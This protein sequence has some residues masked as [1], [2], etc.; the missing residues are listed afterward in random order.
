[1]TEDTKEECKNAE[2]EVESGYRGWKYDGYPALAAW[3]ASSNDFFLLRRFS[4]TSARVLLYLQNEIAEKERQLDAMDEFTKALPGDQGGCG[5]F[6]LDAGSPREQLIQ[7]LVPL[8]KEYCMQ[9]GALISM[10]DANQDPDE[11]FEAFSAVKSR[12]T[13]QKHQVLN[14]Q[15]WFSNHPGAIDETEQEFA[16][17]T[18]DLVPIISKPK[19]VFRLMAERLPG[20][21]RVF[22]VRP[23]EDHV[24]SD[25]TFYHSE[26]ALDCF[27]NWLIIAIGLLM[28]FGPLWWL[29]F[30][31]DATTQLAINTGFITLFAV[32]IASATVAKPFEVLASTAA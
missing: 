28:L 10:A 19:P 31:Q 29:N 24:H 4:R 12:P 25:T 11:L 15:T 30:V 1:M 20:L 26:K 6:R 23:R 18:G 9:T 13:A 22:R 17:R 2:R 5:S 32:L 14:L 16:T 27:T 8:L 21:H 7:D 3:K